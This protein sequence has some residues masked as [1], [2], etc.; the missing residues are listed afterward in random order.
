MRAPSAATPHVEPLEDLDPARVAEALDRSD[1]RLRRMVLLEQTLVNHRQVVADACLE[2][3]LGWVAG[4]HRA[5]ETI[6]VGTGGEVAACPRDDPHKEGIVAVELVRR[7]GEPA[8][9]LGVDGVALVGP[10]QGDGED[11]TVVLQEHRRI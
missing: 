5:D 3:V 4:D 1:D 6:E 7:V 9:H 8:E 11:R 2:L 10:V